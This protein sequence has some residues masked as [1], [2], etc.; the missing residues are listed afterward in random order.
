[1]TI[2][3]F[4]ES[5]GNFEICFKFF[6]RNF[7]IDCLYL[8]YTYKKY[9]F[10]DKY[11]GEWSDVDNFTF[12]QWCTLVSP[13]CRPSTC[14]SGSS[15]T[16]PSSTSSAASARPVINSP[17]GT[18][19][20]LFKGTVSRDICFLRLNIS[21]STVL[22]VFALIVFQVYLSKAFHYPI[23]LLTCL[24]ETSGFGRVPVRCAR[25]FFSLIDTQNGALRPPPRPWQLRSFSF[26][27]PPPPPPQ[28]KKQFIFKIRVVTTQARNRYTRTYN[29]TSEAHK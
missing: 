10:F 11:S 18:I 5:L 19:L 1:M 8:Q 4:F 26:T 29:W 27:T 28:K 15:C 9:A 12:F 22:S 14:H 17:S 16:P 6:C 25:P 23:Q 20:Y 21:I 24:F 13:S 3:P 7:A 2:Y